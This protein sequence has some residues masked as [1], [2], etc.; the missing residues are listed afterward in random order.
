M[1]EQVVESS[2]KIAWKHQSSNKQS[3]LFVGFWDVH[4]V[5]NYKS[6]GFLIIHLHLRM[7]NSEGGLEGCWLDQLNA[8]GYSSIWMK[9]SVSPSPLPI[10]ISIIWTKWVFRKN[11]GWVGEEHIETSS[12]GL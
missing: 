5:S 2:K 6:H 7:H 8:R 10:D 1:N 4:Q 3:C 9:S 11:I 12:E